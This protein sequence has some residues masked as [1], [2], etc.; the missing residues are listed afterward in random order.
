MYLIVFIYLMI[1]LNILLQLKI[2]ECLLAF[3]LNRWSLKKKSNFR[4]INKW[5]ERK[6]FYGQR[7]Q[8]THIYQYHPLPRTVYKCKY[9]GLSFSKIQQKIRKTQNNCNRLFTDIRLRFSD[10][11]KYSECKHTGQNHCFKLWQDNMQFFKC[12]FDLEKLL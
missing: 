3:L 6:H 2:S 5:Q 7:Y 11:T 4:T 9:T 12:H 10:S 8:F 1:L